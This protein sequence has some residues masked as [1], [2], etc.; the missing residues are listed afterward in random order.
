ME[1]CG[2]CGPL[3]FRVL[4]QMGFYKLR[5]EHLGSKLLGNYGDSAPAAHLIGWRR[6]TCAMGKSNLEHVSDSETGK[7]GGRG[8]KKREFAAH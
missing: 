1:Q 4:A 3:Q 6:R 7:K 8:G 2:N 5:K